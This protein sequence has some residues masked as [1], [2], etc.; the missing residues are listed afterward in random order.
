LVKTIVHVNSRHHQAIAATA[1]VLK[2]VAWHD[3]TQFDGGPLIEA[4]EAMDS[5]RWALGVQWHPENLV[6]LEGGGGK[7]ARDLFRAFAAQL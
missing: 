2:A 7:A 4:V 1:P 6:A 5:G 3:G